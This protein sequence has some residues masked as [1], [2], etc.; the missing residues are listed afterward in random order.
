MKEKDIREAEKLSKDLRDLLSKI[1]KEEI[2][3]LIREDREAR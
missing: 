1:P 2:V 3:K